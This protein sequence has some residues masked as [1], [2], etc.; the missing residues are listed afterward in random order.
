MNPEL[1]LQIVM[2]IMCSLGTMLLGIGQRNMILPLAATIVAIASFYLTVLTDRVRLSRG[3]A[4]LAASAAMIIFL[5]DV[6]R[7]GR[8]NQLLAIA[9]LLVYLQMVLMFQNKS[10]RVYGQLL[11]LSLLQVVVAAALNL[12]PIFGLLVV[13]YMMLGL[14]AL[15]LLFT[16][17]EGRRFQPSP[18]RVDAGA[19]PLARRGAGQLDAGF[20]AIK[21]P[22]SAQVVSVRDLVRH[23][24]GQ[25]AAAVVLAAVIFFVVPRFGRQVLFAQG[26]GAVATIGFNDTVQ[27]G[28]LGE[29][30][31]D[32]ASVM[33]VWFVDRQTGQPYIVHGDPLF[34]GAL[35]DM[36]NNG[37]WRLHNQ[38]ELNGGMA[39]SLPDG[40]LWDRAQFEEPIDLPDADRQ[41]KYVLQRITL[42]EQP[43]NTVFSVY[44]P[45]K[46]D[47]SCPI[48]FDPR[49][50][51]LIR[52]RRRKRLEFTL[53]TNGL[54]G[55]LQ[56]DLLPTDRR[57]R[58]DYRRILTTLP[59]V[60]A[61]GVDPLARL[62]QFAAKVVSAVPGTTTDHVARAR[63]LERSLRD[64]PQFEY[65]LASQ[66]RE[67]GVDLIEDFVALHRRG[68]CE[69]FSSA[70]TLMLRSQGIPARMVLGFKGGEYNSLGAYYQV[71]KLHAHSW[72]EAYIDANNLP[73]EDREKFP[74]GAWMRLD[75]T[76]GSTD[77]SGQRELTLGERA[78]DWM[79]YGDYLWTNYVVGL[80]AQRQRD[81]IYSP[82][83]TFVAMAKKLI[84]R[85]TWTETLPNLVSSICSADFW[86][87]MLNAWLCW[88]LVMGGVLL[89]MMLYALSLVLR[90]LIRQFG[91]RG[92]ATRPARRR[93]NRE[94]VAFYESLEKLL[95]TH[96]MVR[97][98]SQTPHEFAM[99]VG[100][101][102]SESPRLAVAAGVPRRIVE[103]FYRVRFGRHALDKAE[104]SGVEQALGQLAAALADARAKR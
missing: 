3:W 2:W 60:N 95:S 33:R 20:T 67:Q 44:S 65:S 69:Y 47:S 23:V 90:R 16:Y 25:G 58:S 102:F 78:R 30:L 53:A 79:D 96:G 74:R 84:T 87:W 57:L 31:Q 73:A 92:G 17:R 36:Y 72:V 50:Q 49:R 10:V 63:A 39:D 100:G 81:A 52:S 29:V 68:H 21:G 82:F 88:P 71:R 8:D 13:L 101:Q 12:S 62:R 24:L 41:H 54:S 97:P 86:N 98:A 34:R 85:K 43:E 94:P 48:E 89:A 56:V 93:T 35:V 45:F 11:M 59:K 4:T 5:V 15:S 37:A 27:L 51:Q 28:R 75:P 18:R 26:G 9:N 77:A 46:L 103:M 80:D 99:A 61:Q 42:E 83:S 76:P 7:L 104:T 91:R 1:L 66:P 55:G 14:A 70:L 38:G 32:T 40:N 19:S 6:V 64:S 22:D